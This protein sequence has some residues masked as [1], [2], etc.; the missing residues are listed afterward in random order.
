MMMMDN[1]IGMMVVMRLISMEMMI[2]IVMML[3]LIPSDVAHDHVND[4]YYLHGPRVV[5]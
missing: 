2:I 4:F 3:V 1:Q 5:F